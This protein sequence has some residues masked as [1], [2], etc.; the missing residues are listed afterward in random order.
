[1]SIAS[2]SELEFHAT[3]AEIVQH[4]YQITQAA[5]QLVELHGWVLVVGR[6]AGVAPLFAGFEQPNARRT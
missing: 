3:G 1:V 5:A 2:V 4:R 6:D